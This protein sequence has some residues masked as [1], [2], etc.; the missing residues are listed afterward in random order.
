MRER[1]NERKRRE[2]KFQNSPL[3]CDFIWTEKS[4]TLLNGELK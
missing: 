2:I 1:H 4:R 3:W